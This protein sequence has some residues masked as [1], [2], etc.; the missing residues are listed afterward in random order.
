M[1]FGTRSDD[2]VPTGQGLFIPSGVFNNS[3]SFRCTFQTSLQPPHSSFQ[4]PA[5]PTSQNPQS[6]P[7]NDR[8]TQHV[9]T[10]PQLPQDFLGNQIPRTIKTA[11]NVHQR[12]DG[13][14]SNLETWFAST[15]TTAA[16]QGAFDDESKINTAVG[17]LDFKLPNSPAKSLLM[18]REARNCK[19][20]LHFQQDFMDR[21]PVEE[22]MEVVARLYEI[23]YTAEMTEQM[24]LEAVDEQ[25]GS[26]KQAYES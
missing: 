3:V 8:S 22:L 9:H 17:L 12:F 5:H 11:H 16:Q 15:E 26:I 21:D 13:K 24:F 10:Q 6:I 14:Q 19:N 2:S 25:L 20:W 7:Q 18:I 4:P 23:Q 1:V